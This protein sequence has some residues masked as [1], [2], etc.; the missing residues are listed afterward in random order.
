MQQTSQSPSKTRMKALGIMLHD[1]VGCRI[2]NIIS[3]HDLLD[4]YVA[5]GYAL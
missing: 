3:G 2:S 5:N 1:R 4:G